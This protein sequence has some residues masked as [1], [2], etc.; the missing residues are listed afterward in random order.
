MPTSLLRLT[1]ALLLSCLA[2]AADGSYRIENRFLA[3]TLEL[4]DGRLRT[5]SIFNKRD[6]RL[7]PVQSSEFGLH[8]V[9]ERL[10]FE[11]G[12]QN[13]VALSAADFQ[14][15]L[16]EESP[17]RLVFTGVNRKYGLELRIIHELRA[18]DFYLRK[19]IEIRSTAHNPV[20]LDRVDVEDLRLENA[21]AGGFGQ[22]VYSGSL[23]FGLEY[24]A[25]HNEAAGGHV[26]LSHYSGE[27][28]SERY[29]ASEKAVLGAAAEGAVK[30]AF[31]EYVSRI[32]SGPV[33]PVLV[34]N[35]WYDMQREG[36]TAGNAIGRMRL[37]KEKLL[38]PYGLR[39]DSFVLDDGWDDRNSVWQIHAGRFPGGFGEFRDALQAMG[40]SLGLWFG[41]IGGYEERD[42]RIAAGR[43]LG[44]EITANGEYFC[45][46][47]TKYREHL[48]SV[49]LD[50]V[51]RDGLNHL[52][53]DGMP[54]GCNAPGHG[55]LPGIY[56][57]EA[58]V[59]AFIDLLRSIRAV[60]PGVF[61]NITTGQWLSP[62][63]LQYADVVFMGGSDYAFLDSVPTISER[64]KAITYRDS[65]LYEDFRTYGDQFPQ[66]SLMTIG[67][68]KGRLGSEGGIGESLASWANNA[69]M[70]FS[71]GSMFTELYV[72]PDLLNDAEWRAL[73]AVIRW[74]GRN[75]DVLLANTY[76]V[77]GDPA[78]GEVYGYAHVAGRAI[79]TLRNPTIEERTVK[80]PLDMPGLPASCHAR[81]VY[82][83][84]ANVAGAYKPGDVLTLPF[85]GYEVLVLELVP[86]DAGLDPAP[87]GL[88]YERRPDG[89]LVT[90]ETAGSV[91][92]FSVRSGGVEI[93]VPEGA[94]NARIAL[95]CEVEAGSPPRL[96]LTADGRPLKAAVVSPQSTE[97]GLAFGEGRWA[98][99]VAPLSSGL[100]RIGI[101]A[102]PARGTLSAYLLMDVPLA[103]KVR[104]GVAAPSS[105][106]ALPAGS[107]IQSRTLHLA[108]MP[109]VSF[110]AH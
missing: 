51:R 87:A 99:F 9:F 12:N 30:S 38:D 6:H 39:L 76:P 96:T 84:L 91:P 100:N 44:Y 93:K 60:K 102:T 70:N 11:H 31:Q 92:E 3:R 7:Y 52:K 53:F 72:S 69:V 63:W 74:A 80:L 1:P 105:P 26:L 75:Q 50:M 13:P 104:T 21:S 23:F 55:H 48:K 41:P 97:Q 54:Y 77:L 17:E 18:E 78:K 59:R 28:T 95:L 5:T 14:F 29:L 68:I 61:L 46:A 2:V 109:L 94:R 45:L 101:A 98:F 4:H 90:Y 89:A 37:L 82:P 66:S 65:V 49:V 35:T 42:L 33:R 47:G 106:D 25:S 79:V 57:R 86:G 71:R 16:A 58:H 88:R 19:W 85:G 67:I 110:A 43:K 36:L 103:A 40:T 27:T 15:A 20:F 32:R 73:G 83:Y 56:S 107:S 64:D 34:F 22:P 108:T 24:P 62:W 81:I 8:F 10:E